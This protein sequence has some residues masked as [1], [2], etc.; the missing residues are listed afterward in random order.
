MVSGWLVVVNDCC[1]DNRVEA[2]ISRS[3]VIASILHTQA[4][5]VGHAILETGTLQKCHINVPLCA[6]DFSSI[7]YSVRGLG[8]VLAVQ[9]HTHLFHL[10]THERTSCCK[11]PKS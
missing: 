3:A 4:T 11:T 7:E 6:E 1:L 8:R 9:E 5:S 10:S 2:T